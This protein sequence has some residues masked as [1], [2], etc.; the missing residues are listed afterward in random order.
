MTRL[1][2]LLPWSN[3]PR[4]WTERLSFVVVIAA[5]AVLALYIGDLPP[6][7]SILISACLLLIAAVL[8]R[9]GW[10]KA[11]GP[12]LW[13]DL[14][15]TS[16]R[17]RTYFV[18]GTYLLILFAVLSM[19]YWGE[20]VGR[21]GPPPSNSE[22]ARFASRFFY[23]FL[24]TQF[25]LIV[26]LTPAYTAGAVAD[27]KQKKTIQFLL[28]T[29]L[30]SH[31][32]ILGKLGS[33]L[34]HLGLLL[35]AGL[36][37]LGVV[38][39]L[40]GVDP[41]LV[42]AGFAGTAVTLASAAGVSLLASVIARPPRSALLLAY[43]FIILY[44]VLCAIGYGILSYLAWH[45][46]FS[47]DI[48]SALESL[49]NVIETGNPVEAARR[50]FVSADPIEV[51]LPRSLSA[52]SI[53]HGVVALASVLTASI[54]LRRTSLGEPRPRREKS[55]AQRPPVGDRAM[56]WKEV[57]AE[58]G[59]ASQWYILV[60]VILLIGGTIS[61]L[62]WAVWVYS[63]YKN[64]SGYDGQSFWTQW[65]EEWNAWVRTVGTIL[66]CLM[67][68]G[69]AIRAAYSIRVERDRESFDSLLTSPLSSEE[70]LYGKWLGSILS[71][72]LMMGLLA[73]VW[74]L[75]LLT[76]GLHILAAPLLVVAWCIYAG[77]MASVGLWFSLVSR[78]SARAVLYTILAVVGLSV[79][80]WLIWL[81]CGFFLWSLGGGRGEEVFWV[82]M[83]EGGLTPPAVLG[84]HFPFGY[85]TPLDQAFP[86]QLVGCAFGGL[87]V[88]AIFA[89][90]VWQATNR[91]FKDAGGRV[92]A[93]AIRY[94][95]PPPHHL[96]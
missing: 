69:V 96:S 19:M 35:L 75:G 87:V 55:A 20:W 16:R 47:A 28:V 32:I 79:G 80:H 56:V 15:R 14:V 29:D 40:G 71:V 63:A 82:A 54:M 53:F 83:I 60:P 44:V 72:R 48:S 46:F 85:D 77:A 89:W 36:P 37:V 39:F 86:G 4:A 74:G 52:Y 81:P 76:G 50:V 2:R 3:S 23:T 68:F 51:S 92:D 33:R 8:F 91:R 1:Q 25:V 18:R 93:G 38:Q 17:A 61:Y 45:S 84:L 6:W 5:T 42:L 27:E 65:R 9:R 43:V 95:N 88:W 78:S 66:A 64:G 13:Y 10:L 41:H 73:L 22:I 57:Y 67:L 94:S 62:L 70:I 7:A 26:F 30:R 21:Y 11:F 49:I 31:E 58:R 12:I 90:T 34:A 24:I 59:A